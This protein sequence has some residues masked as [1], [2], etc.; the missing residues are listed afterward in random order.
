MRFILDE[1]VGEQE[2]E[3]D[4]RVGKRGELS[5]GWLKIYFYIALLLL[6]VV[7]KAKKDRGK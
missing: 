2:R 1:A 3:T 4:M 5:F 7:G 6:L